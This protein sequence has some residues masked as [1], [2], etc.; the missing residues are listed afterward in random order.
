MLRALSL[1]DQ[2]VKNSNIPCVRG[3]PWLKDL[4]DRIGRAV[5]ASRMMRTVSGCLKRSMVSAAGAEVVF[6][7]ILGVRTGGALVVRE[8][9]LQGVNYIA[10]EW[11]Q[12]SPAIRPSG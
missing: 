1:E 5:C 10:G 3:M 8:Q 6:G 11:G 4:Q 2:K 9:L 12:Q 7:V